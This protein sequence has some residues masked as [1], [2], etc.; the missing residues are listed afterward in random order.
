MPVTLL[1]YN[2]V[3]NNN[4]TNIYIDSTFTGGGMKKN[5]VI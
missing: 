3:T 2:F 4:L 5:R 1:L